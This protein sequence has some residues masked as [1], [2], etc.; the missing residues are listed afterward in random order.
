M[1]TRGMR[2]ARLRSLWSTY[3]VVVVVLGL[4]AYLAKSSGVAA[5]ALPWDPVATFSILGFDP[6]TG[7]VGGAVQ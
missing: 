4:A 3:V 6:D 5:Q 2:F 1:V 7:D